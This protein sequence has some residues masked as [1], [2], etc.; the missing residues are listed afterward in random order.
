[1][2][3]VSCVKRV[4]PPQNMRLISRRLGSSIKILCTGNF[5]FC[6]FFSKEEVGFKKQGENRRDLNLDF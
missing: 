2:L 1:M 4:Q 6:N 5:F 3:V